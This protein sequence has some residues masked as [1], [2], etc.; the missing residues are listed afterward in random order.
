[1]NNSKNEEVIL[2]ETMAIFESMELVRSQEKYT[3][4]VTKKVLISREKALNDRRKSL[5]RNGKRSALI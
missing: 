1:M 4:R 5:D 2:K 3:G